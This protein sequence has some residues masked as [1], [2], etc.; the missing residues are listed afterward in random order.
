MKARN[1]IGGAV[2][3]WGALLALTVLLGP[4][5]LTNSAWAQEKWVDL[6][7]G[8]SFENWE[9]LGKEKGIEAIGKNWRFKDG[10]VELYQ[11]V[12]GSGSILTQEPVEDFE[13]SFF[14]KIKQ[15]ANNGIKY[16]VQ[17][18]G[19]QML[20]LEYQLLD[21]AT[22]NGKTIAKHRTA[23]IYDLF[24]PA[25]DKVLN[26]PGQLN[27]GRILVRGE[28]IEHWLNGQRVVLA[29]T[30]ADQ[31]QQ[32]VDKSKFRSHSQFGRNRQG[33]I[34]ITDHGGQ[35]WFKDVMMKPLAQ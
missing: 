24:P 17:T 4:A 33:K 5:G 8:G 12:G 32:A 23:S 14:W 10:W 29:I 9:R 35:I 28:R 27:H 26:Q 20:G 15:N 18:Y 19:K 1:V 30:A 21:D 31:W 3:M 13:L 6:F 2:T 22:K 11:P 25:E 34:M 7:P 16:R